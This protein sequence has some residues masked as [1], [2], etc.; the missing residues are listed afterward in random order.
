MKTTVAQLNA[1]FEF[2]TELQERSSSV[3]EFCGADSDLKTLHVAPADFSADT[4]VL[5][6]ATCAAQLT[7]EAE[8]DLHHWRCLQDAI[9]SESEAVQITSHR[10]LQ[11]LKDEAWAA[12]LLDQMF[13]DDDQIA[14]ANAA[15]EESNNAVVQKDSNG[16][17]LL[18]GDSVSLIKDL[19]VKGA[20]FTAKRGTIVK[21]ISLTSNP[22]H[23]EGRI[24]GTQLVLLTCFMKKAN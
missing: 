12:A 4:C 2:L 1:D 6:C 21:N 15:E 3:C 20:G 24:N 7:G 16:T 14:W 10:L 23:I 5:A 17:I 22:N 13:L 19:E 8:L 18:E 9:W 11:Q